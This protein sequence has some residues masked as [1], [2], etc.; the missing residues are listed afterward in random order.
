MNF[1]NKIDKLLFR[2]QCRTWAFYSVCGTSRWSWHLLENSVKVWR[3]SAAASAQH[4][5]AVCWHSVS[6][7]YLL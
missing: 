3:L 1:P 4:S 7:F 6:L 2:C 5:S